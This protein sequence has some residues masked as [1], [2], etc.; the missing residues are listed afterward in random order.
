MIAV[1]I[2]YDEDTYAALNELSNA[3]KRGGDTQQL[4]QVALHLQERD[5]GP[6]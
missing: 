1:E 5:E 6:E 2:P 3:H 4:L